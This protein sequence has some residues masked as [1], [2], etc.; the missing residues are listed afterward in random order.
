MVTII[1]TIGEAERKRLEAHEMWYYK[2]VKKR[3]D[4]MIGHI[5]RYGELLRGILES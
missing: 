5:L 1:Y 2:N 3:R 4:Q